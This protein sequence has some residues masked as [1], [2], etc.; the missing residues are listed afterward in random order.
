MDIGN[1]IKELRKKR[2]LSQRDLAVLLGV[3]KRRISHWEKNTRKITAE[4]YIKIQE[5][6][7]NGE[8]NEQNNT[9]HQN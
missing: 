4:N 7:Q 8:K 2:G 6:L 9:I 5:I 3:Q 1:R